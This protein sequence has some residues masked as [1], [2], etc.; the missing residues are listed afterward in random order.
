MGLSW[1]LLRMK[2]FESKVVSLS[3]SEC[4]TPLFQLSATLSSIGTWL[5]FIK[6]SLLLS[7]DTR[8]TLNGQIYDISSS[9]YHHSFF[10]PP[11]A[12]CIKDL[13]IQYVLPFFKNMT[14]KFRCSFISSR[15]V[16]HVEVHIDSNTVYFVY[17]RERWIMCFIFIILLKQNVKKNLILY[18]QIYFWLWKRCLLR[19]LRLKEHCQISLSC[20]HFID[21]RFWLRKQDVFWLW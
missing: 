19:R 16:D 15:S 17:Y 10:F 9:R 18:F 4:E 5:V 21:I 2:S 11:S 12:F 14:G 1:I 3:E 13:I 7:F 6:D 8:Q 20:S